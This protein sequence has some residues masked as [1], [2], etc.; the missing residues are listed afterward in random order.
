MEDLLKCAAALTERFN[1]AELMVLRDHLLRT[2]PDGP[3]R[4]TLVEIIEGQIALREIAE[5]QEP[6]S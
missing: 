4:Q 3:A 2:L 6:S 1:R 5:V